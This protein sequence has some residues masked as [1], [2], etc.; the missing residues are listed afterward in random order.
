MTFPLVDS[1]SNIYVGQTLIDFFPEGLLEVTKSND[2]HPNGFV[3]LVTPK[4]DVLGGDT[5]AGPGYS[6]G[7]TSPPIQDL[8]LP[9]DDLS[10][11]NRLRFDLNVLA[12]MKR[13]N[14]GEITF[15]RRKVLRD[16][17]KK[18][19]GG[20]EESMHVSYAPVT[21]QSCHPVRSD[22]FTRGVNVSDVLV[23][24]LAYIVPAD[25]LTA[26]FAF[27]EVRAEQYMNSSA[28][29]L[30]GLVTAAAAV[31]TAL[32]ALVS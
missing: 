24:S 21:I 3:I 14:S 29:L 13:G 7:E 23:A 28:A 31:T 4:N 20:K 15:Y 12:D 19:C 26:P 17:N 22:H 25:D 2:R 30:I 10:S 16:G 11:Q 6:M 18:T 27:I 5:L 8:V 1:L 9:C 32:L